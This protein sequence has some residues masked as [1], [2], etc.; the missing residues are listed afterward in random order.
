MNNK[1]ISGKTPGGKRVILGASLPLATPFLV[2]IFPVYGCNFRCGYCLHAL[3]REKRGYISGKTSM[4]VSLYKKCIDDMTGFNDKLKM[5]RFAGIGEPL[6]HKDIVGMV[7]YAKIKDIAENIDIVTNG[8][9]LT[10]ELSQALIDAGLDRLRISIQGISGEQYQTI[11]GVRIDF[12]KFLKNIQFFYQNRGQTKLHIKIIDCAL[13]N[14]AEEQR[15]FELFGELCDTIALEHLTPTVKGIDYQN[16]AHGKPLDLTQ[17][18][19][20]LNDAAICP[21]P[22]YMIQINPDGAVVPCC[23]MSYPGVFG[24]AAQQDIPTIW[25][26]VK[27]SKFR[28]LLLDGVKQAGPVCAECSL[29]KYGLF[30]EDILEPYAQA[31]KALYS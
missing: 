10:Q 5:L 16:L 25:N 26:G 31:L 14:E 7:R 24:N 17:S 3:P 2:Q 4:D 30:P 13:R 11:S 6:L 9:L 15:F 29:Y 21:Q 1:D 28:R 20:Y 27:L 23:S 19:N 12:E 18:G 8:V 22:F